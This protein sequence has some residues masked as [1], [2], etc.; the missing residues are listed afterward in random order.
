MIVLVM[1]FN[2]IVSRKI[3]Y[4]WIIVTDCG[5]LVVVLSLS[6]QEVVSSSPAQA[7]HVKPKTFEIGSDSPSPRAHHS[8]VRITGLSD[9]TLKTE[10]PCRSWCE[11]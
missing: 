10:V 6:T 2:N 4:D 7:G 8:E 5:S 11:T 3:V 9:M 1:D